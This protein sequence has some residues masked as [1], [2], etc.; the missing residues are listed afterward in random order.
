VDIKTDKLPRERCFELILRVLLPHHISSVICR[1]I[2]RCCDCETT[3]TAISGLS[4]GYL[5]RG[6][7][8]VP[9]MNPG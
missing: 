1:H 6:C 8:R 3:L 9:E 7:E 4:V 5:V 2:T